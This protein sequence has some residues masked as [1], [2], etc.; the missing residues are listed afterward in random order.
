[1]TYYL[2]SET[3]K[4]C[5]P[6]EIQNS[7]HQ[8]VAVLTPEEYRDAKPTFN[9]GIDIEVDLDTIQDTKALVNYDSLTGT[10]N[11]P[12]HENFTDQK[13]RFAF[14]LDEKGIV[15]IDSSGYASTLTARVQQKKRWKLPSLERFIYDFLEETIAN[16]AIYLE[17]VEKNLE[18]IE[19]LIMTGMMEEY[20]ALVNDIRYDLND[21]HKHYEHM[22]DLATE[23][24]ENENEFFAEENLRYFRTF[25]ERVQRLQDTVVQLRDYTVQLRDMI[26]DQLEI[27]QNRIMTLLTVITT[28]FMPLTLIAGWYGMNFKYMPE[29]N[30]IYAYPIVIAVCILIVVVSL[31]WFRKNKWL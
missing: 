27:K 12:D 6:E 3:L 2:I 23:L 5:R 7:E 1:M 30:Y 22:I 16:D 13:Y 18:D 26:R 14:A 4:E 10:L 11:I 20:P 21:L 9:M 28:I 15:L 31:I 29:L 25:S 8:F 17:T 19:D 24:V